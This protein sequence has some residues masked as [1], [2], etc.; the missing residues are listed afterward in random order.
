MDELNKRAETLRKDLA[1]LKNK[2][3][4]SEC[5]RLGITSEQWQAVLGLNELF[6]NHS[7]FFSADDL[8][9][10]APQCHKTIETASLALKSKELTNQALP[11]MKNFSIRLYSFERRVMCADATAIRHEQQD[12]YVASAALFSLKTNT[13]AWLAKANLQAAHS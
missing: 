12:S 6:E 1:E 8:V 5:N 9:K 3:I 10:T 2:L 7:G 4:L 11:I 13:Q